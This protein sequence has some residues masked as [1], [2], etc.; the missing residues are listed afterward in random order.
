MGQLNLM[1]TH[2]PA[3]GAEKAPRLYFPRETLIA[4]VLEQ[5]RAHQQPHDAR[6]AIVAFLTD[7]LHRERAYAEQCLI[8]RK[9]GLE[10]V[11][12]LSQVMDA[13]I[14]AVFEAA[15][16]IFYPAENPTTAEQIAVAAVGGYG[17][18]TLAPGSDIDLL[19]LLPYKT[20]PWSESVIEVILYTLWDLKLKVGHSTR[21]VEEC[22][23]E[24]RADMTIR[25]AL[26]EARFLIGQQTLYDLFENRFDKEIVVGTAAEFVEAKLA[27]REQRVIRAGTSRYLVEPN[28]KDGKGGLRDLNTLFWIA[29]Y[30]YRVKRPS[31][32]VPVGLFDDDE[33]HLFERCEDFLW[34]VRC[35]MHYVTQRAEER[36]SFDLQRAIAER[37]GYKSHGGLSSVERFMKRY[38]LVAKDVGDLTGIVCMALQTR[39]TQKKPILRRMLESLKRQHAAIPDTRDFVLVGDRIS[40]AR[41]DIFIKDPVNLLRLFWFASQLDRMI[42][43]DATRLVTQSLRLVTSDL[44]KNEEANRLFVEI[45]NSRNSPE[46]LLRRMNETGL[47]GRFIPQFG[48]I[49]AMMQFNMYHHYTVDEHLLRSVGVFTTLD[50]GLLKD[51]LP[52][53]NE[54][55]PTIRNRKVLA[56]AIF[57]HDIAKGRPEDHSVAGE[58]VARSLCPRLGLNESETEAV[59]WLI[60]HHLDMSTIAQSR[61]LSDPR[62]IESFAAIVQTL[63]RLKMLLVLTV[64]DIM[65]VGPGV[66]N[67][68]KG[69][70]LR[71]LFWETEIILAGGHSTIDR[72]QRVKHAQEMTRQSLPGWS[73]PEID[74]YIGRHFPAYWLKVD[75]EHRTRHA[76]FLLAAERDMQSMTTEVSTDRFRGITELTVT[77]PDHP[78][79]LAIITG[80]CAAAGANIVD[81]QIFT[82]TDGMALDTISVSRAFENDED[83]LRRAARVARSI[84]QALKGDIRIAE[85]VA[86]QHKRRANHKAFHV[87]SEV[88]I[89]NALS[90]RTTVVEV[91]GLDRPGLLYELTTALG[92]LNLNIASAHIATF[93]EKAVDVFYVTDLTG[94]KVLH[95][96]RIKTIETTLKSV[97]ENGLDAKRGADGA[98]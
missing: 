72:A 70:L 21:S 48:R 7:V 71:T 34:R 67:G 38:F 16:Q 41:Q 30:A 75:H 39:H 45:L 26:L 11:G 13:M 25:T 29:K 83:E 80:A 2:D 62:T 50:K 97:L 53:A 17:R 87:L 42:H 47:L 92:K 32:L 82:T 44:R 1:Q 9:S 55:L 4:S 27:E 20:T 93:G 90:S 96:G 81:A 98:K 61:D 54:I 66:W 76:R 95:A 86:S 8:E 33:L 6:K 65:A 89:D 40:V 79:L 19:F 43:P 85:V 12:Y 84:E 68:W 64:C 3:A 24:G 22:I 63:E 10:C 5:A 37:M 88:V 57:L 56:V 49:V 15:I 23:R 74:A 28:V 69:Q 31:E 60:A 94:S 18:G 14:A 77:A 73:D 58:R 36:L 78:R 52:V 59:A 91:S 51:D 35:H 46:T